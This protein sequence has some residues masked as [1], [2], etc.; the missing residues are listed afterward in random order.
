MLWVVNASGADADSALGALTLLALVAILGT[1]LSVLWGTLY[2]L[3]EAPDRLMREG[4]R[5][6]G[7]LPPA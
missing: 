4:L 7:D 3:A 5:T 1:L 6:Q 2:T